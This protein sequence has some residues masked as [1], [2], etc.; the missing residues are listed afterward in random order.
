[1]SGK[2]RH[3]F[4]SGTNDAVQTPPPRRRRR[5]KIAENTPFSRRILLDPTLAAA[6]T[7]AAVQKSKDVLQPKTISVFSQRN[8]KGLFPATAIF[9]RRKNVG[10]RTDI[11]VRDP[12]VTLGSS[13]KK[14]SLPW[15]MTPERSRQPVKREGQRRQCRPSRFEICLKFVPVIAVPVIT[16]DLPAMRPPKAGIA[17]DRQHYRQLASALIRPYR[18]PAAGHYRTGVDTVKLS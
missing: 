14:T 17:G 1:M 2:K 3:P 8:P 15:V 4:R 9:H 11:Y 7:G 16:G 10:G 13:L 12:H 5:L 18:R 6:L